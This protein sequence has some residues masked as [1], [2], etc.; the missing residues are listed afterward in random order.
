[1]I[2]AI[3]QPN[4]LPYLG[5]FDKLQR[6]DVFVLYDTA[7][8]VK[9]EYQNR[10]RIIGTHGAP[11]WLTVPVAVEFGQRIAEV[12]IA[13]DG[14][15]FRDR[16]LRTLQYAYGRSRG[17]SETIAA[18]ADAYAAHGSGSLVALNLD[19]LDRVV[20]LLGGAPRRVLASDLGIDPALRSTDAIVA[21]VQAAGA[22]T[23]LSG[24]GGR[25]YLDEERVAAAGI[26]LAWQ[27]FHHPVYA[28]RGNGAFVPNL[29]IVDALCE[30]G[31]Q[32]TAEL[33]ACMP[34]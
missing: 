22:D 4:F 2:C 5:F 6:C 29:S 31:P 26:D 9:R 27:D 7:Q 14:E 3:H 33:I 12:S 21:I 16:H 32:A 20:A 8:F 11:E 10:N 30:L 15:P 23:Y 24:A 28:Q 18:V 13:D 1:M 34:R 19:L 17:G 25:G